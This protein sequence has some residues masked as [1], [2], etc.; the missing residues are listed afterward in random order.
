MSNTTEV[1]PDAYRG[2]NTLALT[3]ALVLVGRVNSASVG[4]CYIDPGHRAS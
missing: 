3:D 1:L 2:N 4:L